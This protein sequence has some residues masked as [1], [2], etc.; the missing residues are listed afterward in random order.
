MTCSGLPANHANRR[1]LISRF[2]EKKEFGF[3]TC[4]TFN[5]SIFLVSNNY[6][7]RFAPIRVIRGL[8]DSFMIDKYLRI[9]GRVRWC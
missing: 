8:S 1:E 5:D 4:V 7:P 3:T 9:N 6:S 2:R